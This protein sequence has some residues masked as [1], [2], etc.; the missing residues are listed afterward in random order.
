MKK[1]VSDKLYL[2]IVLILLSVWTAW[3]YWK[4]SALATS[5]SGYL[6]WAL[7]NSLVV[8]FL[9]IMVTI[10]LWGFFQSNRTTIL[11][12]GII[13]ILFGTA[14]H[15]NAPKMLERVAPELHQNGTAKW[16]KTS[17]RAQEIPRRYDYYKPDYNRS[18]PI[19]AKV[20]LENGTTVQALNISFSNNSGYMVKVHRDRGGTY[21]V[22]EIAE[23]KTRKTGGLYILIGLLLIIIPPISQIGPVRRFLIRLW[24]TF[25]KM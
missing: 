4:A 3:P 25:K 16:L 14:L 24:E 12:I 22:G 9:L 20:L 18:R 19:A 1:I 17:I 10:I 15:F 21:W 13:S 7:S 2:S 11:V 6:I 5:R 23:D 8:L